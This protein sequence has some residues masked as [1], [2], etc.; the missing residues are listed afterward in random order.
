V[1]QGAIDTTGAE[2]FVA[3]VVALGT[4]PDVIAIDA[5]GV[6]FIDSSGLTGSRQG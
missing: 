3:S 2:R 4:H 5:K 6:T 1:V